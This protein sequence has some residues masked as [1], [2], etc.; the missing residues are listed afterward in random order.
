MK[1]AVLDLLGT[2]LVPE[3]GTNIATGTT[4]NVHL[5]LVTVAAVWALPNQL[6]VL[7]EAV[8]SSCLQ[9]Y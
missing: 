8:P 4:S 1:Y 2:A 3:L 9:I 7:A 6:A 5:G